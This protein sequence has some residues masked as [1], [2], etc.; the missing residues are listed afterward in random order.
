MPEDG[1]LI[2]GPSQT[3]P[4]RVL[5][6][7][8]SSVTQDLIQLILSQRGHSVD[9]FSNGKNALEALSKNDYDIALLD[10]HLPDI[11]GLDVVHRFLDSDHGRKVPKF[12]AITGDVKGLLSDPANCEIFDEIAPK[13]LDIDAVCKL[14][15]ETSQRDASKTIEP[16]PPQPVFARKISTNSPLDALDYTL[17]QW[18]KERE[19]SDYDVRAANFDAIVIE[20]VEDLDRL[21]ALP[22][23]H[24]LPVIDLTGEL[25][26]LADFDASQNVSG[27]LDEVRVLIESFFARRRLLHESMLDAKSNGDKLLVRIRMTGQPLSAFL[28]VKQP[29]MIGYNTLLN[30][31]IVQTELE[32]LSSR[33]HVDLTFFDRLHVC[34]GCGSSRFNVREECPSCQSPNLTEQTYIHHFRCAYQ[35]P[36]EDFQVGDQLICP[37][38]SRRLA[39]FGS[40][41]DRPGL[42]VTCNACSHATSEPL[43]GFHCGD[44]ARRTEGDAV[45]T[46]DAFGASLTKQAESYLVAGPSFLGLTS[47]SLRFADLPIDLVVGLNRAAQGFTESKTPF[48]LSYIRYEDE[49]Q[50]IDAHGRRQISRARKQFLEGMGQ[51]LGDTV[52]IVPGTSYDFVLGKNHEAETFLSALE[53]ASKL[54]MQSSKFDLKPSFQLF[55]PNDL[56]S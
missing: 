26:P 41:Y 19:I 6:V 51:S 8:D 40:D 34:D 9:I 55:G 21:W 15:E 4:R 24:L 50:L 17:L 20:R 29:G 28:D 13:P 30:P 39:H 5:L 36:E 11:S 32:K 47:N 46:R 10:F 23:T 16:L 27:L 53:A 31:K 3:R 48:A 45:Q 1:S 2:T 56:I 25:G 12:I 18:P 14:V 54:A 38:C 44:C 42:V 22:I 49:N 33:G 35:G 37:K 7:E 43:V 52:Q